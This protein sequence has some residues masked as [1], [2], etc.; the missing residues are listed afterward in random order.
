MLAE[1][2]KG[3][4]F[5]LCQFLEIERIEVAIDFP[6]FAQ[7]PSTADRLMIETGIRRWS[8]TFGVSEILYN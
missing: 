8:V 1:L 6:A 5:A 3:I 2:E 7:A 4:T